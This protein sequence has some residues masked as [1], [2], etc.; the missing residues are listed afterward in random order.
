LN[1][2]FIDCYTFEGEYQGTRTFIKEVY[3]KIIQIELENNNSSNNRYYFVSNDINQLKNDFEENIFIQFVKSRIKNRTL[4]ILFEYPILI[5]KHKINIAHFQ[6]V[7]PPIKFCKYVVTIHDILFCDFKNYFTKS[8]RLKNYL[9]FFI[10]YIIADSVTTV[11]NHTKDNLK[12]HFYFNKN[13][14]VTKNGV[15]DRFYNFKPLISNIDFYKRHNLR[16][17]ILYVSRFEPRKNHISLL[18]AYVNGKHYKTYDLL[19]IGS[20]TLNCEEFDKYYNYLDYEI[21]KYIRIINSGVNDN[22]LLEYYYFSSIFIYPSLFEGFG[23]PPLEASSMGKPVICSNLT[24]MKDFNFYGKYHIDPTISNLNLSLQKINI[25]EDYSLVKSF[26][27][28][29]YNWEKTAKI[30]LKIFS[31]LIRND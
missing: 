24:A 10:S 2:I 13:I 23:I 22:L 26:I 19:L 31:D 9:S 14:K 30:F 28:K 5:L 3:S 17:Y 1:R 15:S 7:V 21:K 18:K 25:L 16:S 29:E 4:R 8:Y 12:K 11:S 6:Y 20:I 27:I